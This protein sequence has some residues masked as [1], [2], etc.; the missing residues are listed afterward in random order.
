MPNDKPTPDWT[1]AERQAQ[2]LAA[3]LDEA[4][5]DLARNGLVRPAELRQRL[6]AL[7]AEWADERPNRAER[8]EAGKPVG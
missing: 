8:T 5:E 6:N 4:A 2:T 3:L 1:E 7:E